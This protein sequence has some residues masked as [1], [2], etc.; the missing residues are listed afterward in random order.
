MTV[1]APGQSRVSDL[2]PVSRIS[3]T[4]GHRT[5]VA[6]R[7]DHLQSK[8]PGLL[9]EVLRKLFPRIHERLSNTVTEPRTATLL[10]GDTN[11]IPQSP[12]DCTTVVPYV[13]F[14]TIVGKNSAF[15][16]LTQE[17]LEE[18][19]G[20]EFR[21]L[22]MLM[23]AVPLVC[24]INFPHATLLLSSFSIFSSRWRYPSL[25][26]HPTCHNLAGQIIF[27]YQTNIGTCLLFGELNHSISQHVSHV[28]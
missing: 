13:T 12:H 26:W 1:C 25:C 21:A 6:Q 18:L 22:D 9:S 17:Q 14:P 27:R 7:P 19:G 20:V 16:N 2:Q 24:R 28:Y 3:K 4:L 23:W 8:R 15:Q 11:S 10:P 5:P